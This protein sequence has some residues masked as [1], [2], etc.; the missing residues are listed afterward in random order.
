MTQGERGAPYPLWVTTSIEMR[1]ARFIGATERRCYYRVQT[2]D[3]KEL[4]VHANDIQA[5]K[6]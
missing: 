5:N 2:D 4:I 3:G 1:R 6:G